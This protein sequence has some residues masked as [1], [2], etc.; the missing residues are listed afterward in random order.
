MRINSFDKVNQLYKANS[1][2]KAQKINAYGGNDQVQISQMG[3]DFQIAKAAVKNSADIRTDKVD[4]IKK[5]MEQGTYQVSNKDVADKVVD[6]F[7]DMKI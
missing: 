3:K 6:R 5:Q 2:N 1:T 7:F 4:A